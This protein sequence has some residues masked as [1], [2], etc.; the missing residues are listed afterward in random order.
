MVKKENATE[1]RA[2]T[3]LFCTPEILFS[4]NLKLTS[5]GRLSKNLLERQAKLCFATALVYNILLSTGTLQMHF[6]HRSQL[7]IVTFQSIIFL[8]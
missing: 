3:V 8:S 2:R 4:K 6:D 5:Y 7:L 1:G